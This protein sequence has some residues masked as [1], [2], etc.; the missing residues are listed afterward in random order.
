MMSILE[1]MLLMGVYRQEFY[2]FI[3]Q[4]SKHVWAIDEYEY[5]VALAGLAYMTD[6][7]CW[8]LQTSST[9]HPALTTQPIRM[10]TTLVTMVLMR[11][12]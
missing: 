9:V 8:Y 7:D 2:Q 1:M 10:A 11:T 6:E 12:I 5:V 4:M 3:E